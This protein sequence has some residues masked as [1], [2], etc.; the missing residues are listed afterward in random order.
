MKQENDQRQVKE[1][2]ENQQSDLSADK[3][4]SK[5]RKEMNEMKRKEK[6]IASQISK[7]GQRTKTHLQSNRVTQPFCPPTGEVAT[8]LTLVLT[9]IATFATARTVLG[10]CPIIP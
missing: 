5:T 10:Y 2:N 1:S 7:V 8:T 9:I 3:I 4:D 6:R